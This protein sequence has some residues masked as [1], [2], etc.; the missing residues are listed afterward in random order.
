MRNFVFFLFLSILIGCSSVSRL[1]QVKGK[2]GIHIEYDLNA[3]QLLDICKASVLDV[4][5]KIHAIHHKKD[6]IELLAYVP[7]SDVDYGSN[8]GLYLYP[9]S[10]HTTEFRLFRRLRTPSKVFVKDV[11]QDLLA[12]IDDYVLDAM[13]I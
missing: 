2:H 7:A 13:G 1:E 11:T 9:K 12:R 5:L 10:D 8:Y 3:E 6:R 4:G